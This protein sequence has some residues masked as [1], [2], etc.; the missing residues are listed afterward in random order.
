MPTTPRLD[1][2]STRIY[3]WELNENS[4]RYEYPRAWP[5]SNALSIKFSLLATINAVVAASALL[6][7][8]SIVRYEKIRKNSFQLYLLFIAIPDFI[9]S[10]CCFLT[11]VLSAPNAEYYS[12]AMC[13]FQSF[14]LTFGFTANGWMNGV[15]VYQVHKLL[16]YS[17]NRRRYFPPTRKQVFQHTAI[18]YVY[19]LLWGML[20]AFNISGVPLESH[21]FHGYACFPMEADR[22]LTWFYYF[23]FL[24]CVIMLP[25]TY[26]FGV[27]FHI[28]WYDL[29]P[30]EGKRRKI[31][32]FLMRII[33]LYFFVWAPFLIVG[34]VGNFVPM[35]SWVNFTTSAITHLQALFTTVV[36]YHTNDEVKAAMQNLMWCRWRED[37]EIEV[38]EITG[39]TTRLSSILKRISMRRSKRSTEDEEIHVD[40]PLFIF[41][42][43]V[44]S[45]LELSKQKRP[46]KAAG[47]DGNGIEQNYNDVIVSSDFKGGSENHN[48]GLPEMS[49]D[50]LEISEDDLE[51]LI[52]KEP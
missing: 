37:L 41:P 15:I 40:N 13:G 51:V 35:S 25:C 3:E 7:I 39:N 10:F 20:S 30:K 32:I 21:A 6:L 23:A 36:C 12:E 42:E 2:P 18:V 17:Q 29:L 8:V 27:F 24:P 33:A 4:T 38:V 50:D 5:S 46:E 19:A 47:K 14:Y 43:T 52:T 22:S 16:K 48:S 26:A 44:E 28:Y 11:C 9:A 45:D 34:V 49:D 1:D 31:A